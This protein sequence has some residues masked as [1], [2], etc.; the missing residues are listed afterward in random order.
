M[1]LKEIEAR[2]A[3]IKNEIETRGAELTVDELTKLENETKELT[4]ERTKLIAEAEQR[5]NLLSNIASG[6]AGTNVRSFE[7]VKSETEE[8]RFKKSYR[9]AYLKTLQR[10]ALTDVEKRDFSTGAASAG[11][12]IPEETEEMIITKVKESAP[13]LDEITLLNVAGMVKI[14][15]EGTIADAAIHTENA[16][17][18]GS[19]DTLVSVSL[20]GYEIVKL[21]RISESVATM[22]VN[23]FEDWLT[24]MLAEKVAEVIENCLINGTG[25]NEPAG[26][27][28]I[29]FVD[30]T[31]GVD[32][33]STK[34]TT[35]EIMKLIGLL[36]S[37]HAK[38]AKFVCHRTTLWNDIMPLRDDSKAPI[39][40]EDGN[41]GYVILGYP[42]KLSDFAT[43][44]NLYFG[45]A[46]A[47]VGNL[48]KGISIAASSESGFAYNSVDYR[49][50]AI[51]DSKVSD[52]AAFVKGAATL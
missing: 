9:T 17:I 42:V 1:R 30:G 18:N 31:N 13:M 46:K 51:F 15:V 29:T 25:T 2:L 21:V 40:K 24:S 48:A 5:S 14:A 45:N 37:R 35:A 22:A 32:Y 47:I 52:E 44:G 36:P 28:S 43:A 10:K 23:A 26:I 50:T 12:V 6:C 20:S 11:A 34:P 7:A 33:A 38:K 27:E 4:E 41:G 16:L 3:Q 8:E 49:G 39:V 19:S